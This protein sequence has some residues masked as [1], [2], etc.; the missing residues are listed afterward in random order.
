MRSQRGV[1]DGLSLLDLSDDHVNRVFLELKDHPGH[2]EFLGFGRIVRVRYQ[3]LAR[4]TDTENV[5]VG[6]GFPQDVP[7]RKGQISVESKENLYEIYCD[8]HLAFQRMGLKAH[9]ELTKL[10]NHIERSNVYLR[11]SAALERAEHLHN[12]TEST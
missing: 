10:R 8:V 5:D 4:K 12:T 11:V 3:N 1:E 9:V 7:L 6:Q 2:F